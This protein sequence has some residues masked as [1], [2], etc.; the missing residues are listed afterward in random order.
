MTTTK[1][2]YADP[3]AKRRSVYVNEANW[4]ALKKLGNG[5]ASAGIRKAVAISAQSDK[6]SPDVDIW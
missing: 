1:R 5:N 4:Q 6:P 3:T 2:P